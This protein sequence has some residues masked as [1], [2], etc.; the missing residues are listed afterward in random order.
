[1][2][3]ASMYNGEITSIIKQFKSVLRYFRPDEFDEAVETSISNLQTIM[4]VSLAGKNNS[5]LDAR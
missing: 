5:R 3:P 4:E 1:M 2:A